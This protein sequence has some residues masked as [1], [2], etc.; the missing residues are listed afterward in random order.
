M[1]G[2]IRMDK[3]QA[4]AAIEAILFSFG[5]SVE[6]SKIAS[7]IDLDNDVTDSYI[8][9]LMDEYEKEDRGIKIIELDQAY[10]LCTKP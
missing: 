9:E 6:L 2:V 4:K 8:R 10:Q 3:T 7:A 5:E 1:Y